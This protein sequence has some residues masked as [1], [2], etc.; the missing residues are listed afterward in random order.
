LLGKTSG[1]ALRAPDTGRRGCLPARLRLLLWVLCVNGGLVAL[2]GLLQRA[3][4]TSHLL[5]LVKPIINQAPES[6][7]GPYAYRANAAQLFNLVWPVG[8]GFWWLLQRA[9]RHGDRRRSSHHFLLSCVLVM[10]VSAL[11][12]L[13]RGAAL[14][15]LGSLFLVA[16]IL[17]SRLRQLEFKTRIGIFALFAAALCFAGVL[18]W[19]ALAGRFTRAEQ[20]FKADRLELWVT[21]WPMVRQNLWLGAGP[22]TMSTTLQLAPG[23]P[24]ERWYAQLH[25]DFLETL[26]TFGIAGSIPILLA[27]GAALA[28][29]FYRSGIP[30]SRVLVYHFWVALAGLLAHAAADFPLQIYSLLFLVIL[31]CAILSALA[32]R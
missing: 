13:S 20:E 32:R 27:L 7:F 4:G 31:Y 3:W 19:E 6:Q 9:A 23:L 29:W 21:V 17:L 10:L 16:V 28:C 25:N 24:P 15:A 11:I 26:A 1:E 30:V 22:G 14:V 8:V 18:G 2:E 5:W 12:S